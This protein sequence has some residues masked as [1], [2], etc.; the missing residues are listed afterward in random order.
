MMGF[1]SFHDLDE[2]VKT[3]FLRGSSKR[4]SEDYVVFCDRLGNLRKT[5]NPFKW[6]VKDCNK[7]PPTLLYAFVSDKDTLI[8]LDHKKNTYELKVKDI[9]P[10]KIYSSEIKGMRSGSYL[11]IIIGG[12]KIMQ[13]AK[14]MDSRG[15]IK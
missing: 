2:Y 6:E 1:N 14:Q 8:L 4:K 5:L 10:S 9:T 7:F 12:L 3:H 15:I 13:I 11:P